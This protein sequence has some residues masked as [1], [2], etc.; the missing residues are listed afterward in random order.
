MPEARVTVY[1]VQITCDTPDVE[2]HYEY[3]YDR[4]ANEP[5][6]NSPLYTQPFNATFGPSGSGPEFTPV[7]AKAFKNGYEPSDIASYTRRG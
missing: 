2:I 4:D 5:T 1:Q 6:I 7:K 3:E